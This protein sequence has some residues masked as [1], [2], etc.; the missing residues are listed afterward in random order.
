MTNKVGTEE[1]I[2]RWNRFADAY[3]ANHTELGDIHKEVFLNPAIFSLI[4]T[5]KNKRVLDAGCGE[6][7]F[8]RL[9]A[10]A[11]AAVTAVDYSPRMIDIAKK[12]TP[13][14]LPIE[15]RHGNCED[16]NMLEDKS[17]DLII[18][19]MVM[20]D[21]ADYEKA[22]QEMHRLLTD[23]GCFIF[24]ILHPCFITPESGWEK[25]KDGK[26]LHWNVDQYFYE[27]TYEQKLG[28]RENMLFFHRTL[29]SYMN[30]LIKTGFMLEGLVE[31]KPSEE[32]LKKYPSFE[33]DF[34]CPDFIVFKL[35]KS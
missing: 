34:R 19:N 25:S 3:A 26:K 6:G 35:R 18:S 8:S 24:S 20:Q 14:D 27:G 31:P 1:A 16:L 32:M 30:T 4:E 28:D 17:F 7:Y 10:K 23:R 21:L 22:F 33:E 9:L 5:V 11:G 12:R 29:T 2:Q 15:Y 13:D